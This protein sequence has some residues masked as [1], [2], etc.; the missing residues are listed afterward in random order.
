MAFFGKRLKPQ[1]FHFNPQHF[2]PAKE[3]REA[4][5]RAARAAA[6]GDTEAIKARISA[7]F[8]G[9]RRNQS[10]AY[11]S[12]KRRSNITVVIT[13]VVLLALAYILLTRF[14]PQIE[15]MVE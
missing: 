15:Q 7:G 2:D 4:R 13:L 11:Q 12:A 8:K 9:P 3:E 14:L 5:I 6:G 10:A 1:G